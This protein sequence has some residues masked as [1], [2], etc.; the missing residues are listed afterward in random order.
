[1]NEVKFSGDWNKNE[2]N[3]KSQRVPL[4]IT[5]HPLL[6]DFVNLINKN[7]NLLHMDQEAQR[8]FTAGPMMTFCGAR[9]LSS[10]LVGAKLYQLERTVGLVTVMVSDVTVVT[11]LQKHRL[12]LVP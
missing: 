9:K 7:L 10:Y 11:M 5:F 8:V 12:L 2:T 6:K 4:V 3:K 1:M